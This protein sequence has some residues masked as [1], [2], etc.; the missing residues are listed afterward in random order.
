MLKFTSLAK[1]SKGE[2]GQIIQAASKN[3]KI[4]RHHYIYYWNWDHYAQNFKSF[5]EENLILA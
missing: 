4:N 5:L 3:L 1:N 2:E